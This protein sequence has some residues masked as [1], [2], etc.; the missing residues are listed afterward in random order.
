MKN[1]TAIVLINHTIDGNTDML[2]ILLATILFVV[3]FNFRT[4]K[5][6]SRVVKPMAGPTGFETVINRHD[7]DLHGSRAELRKQW[8]RHRQWLTQYWQDELKR[9]NAGQI[10]EGQEWRFEPISEKYA[11]YITEKLVLMD[12][13]IRLRGQ[14]HDFMG[15]CEPAS[16]VQKQVLDYFDA[17]VPHMSRLEAEREIRW[18][19]E[20]HLNVDRWN[21]RPMETFQKLFF[22][23]AGLTPEK[24][25]KAS[26]AREVIERM[27]ESET[28]LGTHKFHDWFSFEAICKDLT[29][30][31][32]AAQHGIKVVCPTLIYEAFQD[33]K[34][35][36]KMP[37]DQFLQIDMVVRKMLSIQPGIRRFSGRRKREPVQ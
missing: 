23:V 21:N 26:E 27:T 32:V 3:G 2:L 36:G 37:N 8:E 29:S 7:E 4:R 25:M 34:S 28:V 30:E 5:I 15:L 13:P 9:K 18:I 14:A 1:E 11:E 19:M 17:K 24:G 20:S 31:Y 10:I 22:S 35:E 16:F 33:L 12:F 6:A